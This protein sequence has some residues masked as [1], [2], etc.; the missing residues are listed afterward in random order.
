M[1]I[2]VAVFNCKG[3]VGKTTLSIILTQ[4]ALK[5][6]KKVVAFDQSEQQDFYHSI[7]YLTKEDKF[8]DSL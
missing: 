7:S 8:K 3:G 2:K 5:H 6:N 1:S 4:I